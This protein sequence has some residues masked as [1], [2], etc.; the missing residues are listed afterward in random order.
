MMQK[1]A[2][3]IIVICASAI[4]MVLL[5]QFYW[6][7][8]YY[9]VN[10][11]TFEKEVNMAFEDALKKEFSL[12]CDTIQMLIAK[13]LMDT[14]E[15]RITSKWD[16][17]KNGQIYTIAN[18]HRLK[19]AFKFSSVSFREIN[20]AVMPGDTAFK[21][22]I[23]KRFAYNLRTEDLQNHIV[24]YRTQNL[25]A[26]MVDEVSKYD[27][28]T[29]RLRP[30]LKKYLN[31]RG[32]NIPFGFY[33]RE[34]D[35]T[36]NRSH[37]DKKLLDKFPIITK[38]YPTY[39]QNS[40]QQFVRALFS[41]PFTYVI[42]RTGYMFA[43]SL[44]LIAV[45]AFSLIYL[46]R[47]LLREKRLSAIKNDF[48]GN[49]THEF[50]T[51]IATASAAIEALSGFGVLNDPTRTQR[52][53]SHS[54]NE[55]DKLS[56]LVDK[57]LNIAVHENSGFN[58]KPEPVNIDTEIQYLLTNTSALPGKKIHWLYNNST[59]LSI[60]K[61]DRLYFQHAINNIIDNA[62]KYSKDGD[63]YINVHVSLK[64][65]F[66]IIAVTDD[67][68]GIAANDLPLVFE[69]FYRVPTGKHKVKGHGLGLSYVK[70]IVERHSGWCKIES[71]PD[72]GTTVN[73]AWPI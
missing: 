64:N 70:S 17:T 34:R 68:V 4:A 22:V 21:W 61:A 30:V 24:Y 48:I 3:L 27:F 54:K 18:A 42:A 15:F 63:M 43:G 32:I 67:G 14:S 20:K 40:K 71:E 26:F 5:L 29:V 66:L 39:Q 37:F 41:N 60:V 11:A 58:I 12:R 46:L 62:V 57:V 44:L 13:H 16:S 52:Y 69:K 47:L 9:A 8:N 49:I 65:N 10:Q 53:L 55:L 23:A 7:K 28:D 56:A 51:P 38:S 45:V 72:K 50:K 6:V 35:S 31:E 33:L 2:R 59:G 36:F 1:N 73:L 19:D 25:G